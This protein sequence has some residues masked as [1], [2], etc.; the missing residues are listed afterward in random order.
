MHDIQL[1]HSFTNYL[2]YHSVDTR[3][4]YIPTLSILSIT[5]SPILTDP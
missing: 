1:V 3:F 2:L 4:I 5:L